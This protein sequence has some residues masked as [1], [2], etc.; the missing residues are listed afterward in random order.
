AAFRGGGFLARVGDAGL[1]DSRSALRAVSERVLA[2]EIRCVRAFAGG[3]AE[4][5]FRPKLVRQPN[6]GAER[7]ALLAAKTGERPDRALGD[8]LGH[9]LGRPLAARGYLPD[10]EVALLSME[11]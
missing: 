3:L 1:E 9:F 6:Q 11:L 8:E 5:E 7:R 2:A 4:V 10:R